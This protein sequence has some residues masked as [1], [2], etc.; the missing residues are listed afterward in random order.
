MRTSTMVNKLVTTELRHTS[1]GKAG[2]KSMSSQD[3]TLLNQCINRA[4]EELYTKFNLVEKELIIVPI[5]GQTSYLLDE[6]GSL[7]M[8]PT[9]GYIRD[10]SEN[11]F[12]SD[13]MTILRCFIEDG[14]EIAI[15]DSSDPFS[16]YISRAD[17]ITIP[18]PI[19]NTM[20]FFVYRA[21][22]PVSYYPFPKGSGGDGSTPGSAGDFISK[23][24]SWYVY[25]IET[26]VITNPYPEVLR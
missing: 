25:S 16:V 11:I 23:D 20:Y 7:T 8:H 9:S 13:V 26:E 17:T 15:N 4:I 1:V 2:F 12:G 21:Y 14:K 6:S 22:P 18:N 10:T 19:Q 5:K 24:S 3:L